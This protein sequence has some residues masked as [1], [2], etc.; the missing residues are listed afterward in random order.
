MSKHSQD[1]N[2]KD[3][4]EAHSKKEVGQKLSKKKHGKGNKEDDGPIRQIP[5]SSMG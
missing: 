3:R 2:K 5:S 1:S 4:K